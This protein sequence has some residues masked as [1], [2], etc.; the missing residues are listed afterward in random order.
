[1]IV[2]AAIVFVSHLAI[3]SRSHQTENDLATQCR[4]VVRRIYLPH[5]EYVHMD[6]ID[7]HMCLIRLISCSWCAIPAHWIPWNLANWMDLILNALRRILAAI[8]ITDRSSHYA[9]GFLDANEYLRRCKYSHDRMRSVLRAYLLHILL[10]DPADT[11]EYLSNDRQI[12]FLWYLCAR[13]SGL[14]LNHLV[15]I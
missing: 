1:M 9:T 12:I 5:P 13:A 14:K 7:Y 6:F 3:R 8:S 15:D 2:I 10:M 11:I 4:H